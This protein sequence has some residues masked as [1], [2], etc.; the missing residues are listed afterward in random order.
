MNIKESK[1]EKEGLKLDKERVLTYSQLHCPFECEYCFSEDINPEQRK[2]I[3]YLSPK[4]LEL[5]KQLPKEVSL[6]MLGCDTEFFQSK[7]NS[8]EV[9]ENLSN[10]N[11]DIS[12]ITKLFLPPDFIQKLKEID[13][14]LRNNERFFVFSE[15]ITSI[16][17]AKIWEPK[18]SDPIKRIDTL[19]TAYNKGIKTLVAIRPLLPTI[20]GEELEKIIYLTS[21]FCYGYYSGP[22]YLKKLDHPLL[23]LKTQDLKIEKLQPHWMPEGNIFYKIEKEGQMDLLKDILEKHNKPLFEGAAEGI[24]Y[25]KT[26]EKH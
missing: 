11:K 7:E 20:S 26:Y 24:K 5:I 19:K 4:Q 1:F 22:L 8:L 18:I 25:L 2:N 10:L 23:D 3:S 13:N 6:I 15:T 14:K 12:V 17:S 16:D 21:D 9:L